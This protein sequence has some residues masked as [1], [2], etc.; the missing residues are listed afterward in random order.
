MAAG[1][2][3]RGTRWACVH[4]IMGLGILVWVIETHV[5]DYACPPTLYGCMAMRQ[6]D[7]APC[8]CHHHQRQPQ[9]TELRAPCRPDC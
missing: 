4:G 7:A 1:G 8:C 6:L 5:C 2:G 9:R 3:E